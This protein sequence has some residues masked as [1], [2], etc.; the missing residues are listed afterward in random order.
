ML[1]QEYGPRTDA[2]AAFIANAPTDIDYLLSLV[3][4]MRGALQPF[5]VCQHKPYERGCIY[6]DA[7][8]ALEDSR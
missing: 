3:D 8:K 4:R 6:C 1:E 2:D 7:R 5:A